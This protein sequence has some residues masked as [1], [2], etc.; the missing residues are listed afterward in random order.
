[1]MPKISIIVPIY[2]VEK[3]L[4]TCVDSILVQT[5]KNF[6]LLL[7]NDGS[8]DNC[9]NICDEYGFDDSRIKVFHKENGGVSSAR[10]IGL[11]KAI[12]EW[13]LFV[14][15]DDFLC[16][17]ALQI[18]NEYLTNEEDIMQFSCLVGTN[19]DLKYFTRLK[20]RKHMT[21]SEYSKMSCF[22]PTVWNFCFKKSIIDTYNLRFN[23]SLNYS[24]DQLF[25]L[26]YIHD[27]TIF[28]NIEEAI[29]VYN[30]NSNSAM[31]KKLSI[32]KNFQ[33]FQSVILISNLSG[34]RI[35]VNFNIKQARKLL[36]HSLLYS[37]YGNYTK[38]EIKELSI[39][40]W[41]VFNNLSFTLRMRML[42]FY[43][44]M[45][46]LSMRFY[47]ICLKIKDVM[48][49]ILNNGYYMNKPNP[50]MIF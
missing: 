18:L 40:Y 25:I 24:E 29:Y 37:Y 30:I 28:C 11:E 47:F 16:E 27:N 32:K 36:K 43:L 45:P 19:E 1:M 6:E 14:D 42:N 38:E 50:P 13:I 48:R 8:P 10:N 31:H 12:G 23:T 33:D 44:L 34:S 41:N 22:L 7:I 49:C 35:R 39:I 21:L 2:K 9:G 46:L 26:S 5:F 3:Y 20:T 4:R 15:A 17:N